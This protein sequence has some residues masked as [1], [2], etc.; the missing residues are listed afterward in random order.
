MSGGHREVGE[1][2]LETVKRELYEET[3]AIDFVITPV[4]VYSVIA[5]D[6]FNGKE[7]IYYRRIC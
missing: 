7:T 5:E 6:N 2:I 4:C 1:N 3:G